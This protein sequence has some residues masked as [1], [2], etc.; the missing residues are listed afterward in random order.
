MK[1]ILWGI[2]SFVII[3]LIAF[4]IECL[5]IQYTGKNFHQYVYA[6]YYTGAFP[7]A[8]FSPGKKY[9]KKYEKAVVDGYKKMKQS[10]LVICGLARNTADTLQKTIERIETL[11][12]YFKEYHVVIFENDS[13]DMTRKLLQQWTEKNQSVHLLPCSV[14]DCKLGHPNLY[15]FGLSGVGRIEKMAAFRNYYLQYVKS[16][17]QHYNYMM[18]LDID[19]KGPWSNNGIA[20][21]I[22]QKDW[23]MIAAYGVFSFLLCLLVYDALAYVGANGLFSDPEHPMYNLFKMNHRLLP[24]RRGA[25]LISVQSAFSGLALYKVKSIIDVRYGDTVCEHL[26]LHKQMAEKGH[27]RLYVSPSLL[28]LSGYQ[29]PLNVLSL[30]KQLLMHK[31]RRK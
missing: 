11:G 12:S 20:H 2:I 8:Q 23:D 25:P 19:M 17:Y 16:N 10:S 28:L 26:G 7:E 9:K 13:S 30:M 14:K 5:V 21:S 18:V 24:I 1:K 27:N 29:G 4:C 15:S 6:S 22:A 3:V 31:K